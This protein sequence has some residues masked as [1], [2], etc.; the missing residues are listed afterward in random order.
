ML[1]ERERGER[2]SLE[3]KQVDII[4]RFEPHL[5][6]SSQILNNGSKWI[7]THDIAATT[8]EPQDDSMWIK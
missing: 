1:R 3:Y 2:S 5:T 8:V 7:E 6:Q 4:Q